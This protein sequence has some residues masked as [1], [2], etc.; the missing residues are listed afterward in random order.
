M[1]ERSHREGGHDTAP[2]VIATDAFLEAAP[3]AI[4]IVGQDG[5]IRTANGLAEELFEYSRKELIGQKIEMLVPERFRDIHEKQRSAYSVEPRT[6][7]MGSGQEL[8]GRRKDGSEFP[9]EISLSPLATASETLVI[10]IVRDVS[11]R[12]RAIEERRRLE[13]EST[14]AQEISR[15]KDQ[16]LMTLSHELRTPLTAMLGWAQLLANEPSLSAEVRE[17]IR[18]V[19]DN[20]LAQAR[21][22]DDMLEVSRLIS[23][24]VEIQLSLFDP[25]EAVQAAVQTV[26]PSADAKRIRILL[27]V[28]PEVGLLAAD[29]N[30][31]QQIVWNLLANSIKFSNKDSVVTVRL[32]QRES[33]L[34]LAVSDTGAGI[35]PSFLPYVFEPFLQEDGTTTRAH[36]GLGLGLS[37]ARQFVE[38]H[39]GTV[40]AE[41]AGRG[42]GST[43][44]VR[45]PVRPFNGSETAA[46]KRITSALSEDGRLPGTRV[47]CVD[48]D[49]GSRKV[50][51]A[52]LERSGATV[53]EASSVKEALRILAERAVDI[54]VTDVAMPEEDGYAL[55]RQAR[56]IG[57]NVP[58]IALSALTRLERESGQPDAFDAVLHKPLDAVGLASAVHEMLR[59][60]MD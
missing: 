28:G 55:V 31:L 45:I 23:G 32:E 15:A 41:S 56:A 42:S 40:V 17:A 30:R 57:V 5:K 50:V 38:L 21:I 59:R 9:V 4:I 46:P 11:E 22:I 25:L 6:R 1:S 8:L 18:A 7:P 58:I 43:F 13:S 49:V 52:V 3:D 60:K 54:V 24:K 33:T 51:R 14:R 16:F 20:A 19:R 26:R 53:S 34:E 2:R 48:D 39:G 27:E 37:I 12:L 47:L 35:E 29:R 10:S 36:S 44:T